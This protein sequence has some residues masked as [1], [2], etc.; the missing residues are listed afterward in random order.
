MR[1]RPGRGMTI[2][3]QQSDVHPFRATRIGS[4]AHVLHRLY[5]QAGDAR[6]RDNRSFSTLVA[7]RSPSEQDALSLLGTHRQGS[8]LIRKLP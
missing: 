8:G 5:E 4:H 3:L 6:L 7:V 2:L 1:H